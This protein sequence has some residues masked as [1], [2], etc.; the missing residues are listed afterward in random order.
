MRSH[1]I[2][3][4]FIPSLP[5]LDGRLVAP[6]F[7]P[8]PRFPFDRRGGRWFYL[9]RAGVYHA[10]KQ[11]LDGKPG[12]V[13]MPSYHHG[14]EVEAVRAA[15]AALRF[16]RVDEDMR[17]DLDDLAQRLDGDVRVVYVTHF[18]GFA[19]PL[20]ELLALCRARGAA[21]VEDCALA[22]FSRAPDGTP[23]GARGDAA[24]FCLYK[25]LPVPHGGLLVGDGVAVPRLRRP[26]IAS[27][28]HHAAG[29]W[30]AHLE[31]ADAPLGRT[32]REAARTVARGTIDRVL[33]T[34][35]TNTQ[36]LSPS[37]LTL[38]ASSL[39]ARLARAIDAVD[40]VARRRRNFRRLAEQLDG[41]VEVVG[42]PLAEGECPLFVP[43]RVRNKRGLLRLLGDAGI[44]A[45][46]FWSSGDPAC[47]EQEFREVAM[48]R[49]T[50]IELPCHQSLDDSAIDFVARTV[51]LS[52][53]HA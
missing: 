12:V 14:V 33:A 2:V 17:I 42:A 35:K 34:V 4:R 21:L 23:L 41:V 24:L 25:S 22:L 43:V 11:F 46:D 18:V 13:L 27:T 28:L 48:L 6:R 7:R 31:L 8:P 19:Q 53:G 39:T 1:L 51:K 36:H 26:P 16:Y 44:E 20:G 52:V 30:L 37:E 3:R 40:V 47:D 50:I 38:G 32:L 49:R 29:L 9:A 5:T 45:V 15:G 10:I